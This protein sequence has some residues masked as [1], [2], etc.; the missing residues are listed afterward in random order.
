MK[1]E[2]LKIKSHMT[3]HQSKS[4]AVN[5]N[6]CMNKHIISVRIISGYKHPYRRY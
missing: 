1:T 2:C 6:G 4:D 3:G 5:S